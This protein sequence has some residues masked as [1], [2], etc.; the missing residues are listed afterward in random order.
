MSQLPCL[1]ICVESRSSRAQ[2]Q[3]DGDG[4]NLEF[5]RATVPFQIQNLASVP[6]ASSSSAS[7]P[8][9]QHQNLMT[10]TSSCWGVALRSHSGSSSSMC[11]DCATAHEQT[12]GS[13]SRQQR[14]CS[15]CCTRRQAEPCFNTHAASHRGFP[16]MRA[17]M[18]P[19]L[20]VCKN[21]NNDSLLLAVMGRLPD[22]SIRKSTLLR[23]S[24]SPECTF[25]LRAA[26]FAQ[27]T[28]QRT[29]DDGV[30]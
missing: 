19:L 20:K 16:E 28:H 13:G 12:E 17:K 1:L 29:S 10:T 21:L 9:H 27:V 8:P 15:A 30:L 3:C 25:S 4:A 24:L 18:L 7:L 14:R 26:K 2:A 22:C 5:P 23:F 11:P 6:L